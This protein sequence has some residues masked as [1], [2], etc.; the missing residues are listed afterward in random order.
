MSAT[1]KNSNMKKITVTD[2]LKATDIG[3]GNHK[4][5]SMELEG[6]EEM[7]ASDGYHT[8]TELYDHRIELFIA[9]CRMMKGISVIDEAV[10]MKLEPRPLWRSLRH[11]NGQMYSD[12]FIMGIG[13]EK[14]KQIT[15]HLPMARWDETGFVE[16]LDNAPEF[17]GHKSDDVVARIKQL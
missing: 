6:S 1:E 10:G 8:F 14:G 2:Y 7:D 13:K 9:L 4:F 12:W 11:A 17:D 3:S 16:T 5:S 15:Y